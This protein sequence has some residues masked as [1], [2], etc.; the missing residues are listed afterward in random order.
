MNGIL[1]NWAGVRDGK[2]RRYR[3]LFLSDLHL[4]TR[5]SQAAA[6]LE[7]LD[8]HEADTIYLVD[9]I[10]DI[11]RLQAGTRWLL[12]HGEVLNRLLVKL[13]EGTRVIYVPGNHDEAL[14]NCA[15]TQF[16]GIEIVREATHLTSDGRRLLVTHGDEFDGA[17]RYAAWK[18]FVGDRSYE[19]ALWCDRPINSVRRQFG[20][21]FWSLSNYAKARVK[22]ATTFIKD[23]EVTVASEA[24][25]RGFDGVVC[26]HIHYPAAKSIGGVSYLNCGDWVENCTAVA[27]DDAGQIRLIR[28]REHVRQKYSGTVER[29]ILGAA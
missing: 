10:V 6:V 1:A 19:F 14:R 27:E 8:T 21:S 18:R 25:R 12:A 2:G 23:F 26:G 20:L 15:G 11:W 22:A 16:A 3:T 4:G 5:A 17:A 9:D 28:W 13:N 7:F 24:R 29:I